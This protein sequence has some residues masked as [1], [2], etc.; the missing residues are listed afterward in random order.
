[1]RL[2]VGCGPHYA[3]GWHN[4]DVVEVPGVITPDQIVDPADPFPFP[5]GSLTAVYCGHVLEHVPWG[6]VPAWLADL[7]RAM[8]PGAELAVVGPDALRV[9]DRWKAGTEEWG[10]VAGIIEGVGAYVDYWRD[11]LGYQWIGWDQ[12][13]HHWN[14]YEG[15]VVHALTECGFVD[16]TPHGTE[17]DGRLNRAKLAGWPLVDDSPCQFAVTCRKDPNP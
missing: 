8:A 3:E 12:D 6:D 5:D 1:M 10:K 14:C 4:T 7:Q 17:D 2:N 11:T 16:V 13:R 9:L 15:R